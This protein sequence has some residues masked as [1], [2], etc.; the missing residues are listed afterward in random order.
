MTLLE[1][2][3][4]NSTDLL[5]DLIDLPENT[6]ITLIGDL[7][8]DSRET[9]PGDLFIAHAGPLGKR[10]EFIEHAITQGAVMILR[11]AALNTPPLEIIHQDNRIIPLLAVADLQTK[12]SL[13]ASKF[14]HHPDHHLTMIGITGTNGKTSINYF[15]AQGLQKAGI[16]CGMIG[17]LGNGFPGQLNANPNNMTTPDSTSLHK[18]LAKLKAQGAQAVAMEVSSH[19]LTQHRVANI[20]FT[21]AV[22]TNLTRDHLDYHDT[23]ENYGK[24]KETLFF[25]PGLKYAVINLDDSF[26]KALVAKIDSKVTCYTYSLENCDHSPNHIFAQDIKLT[27]H[28]IS[29]RLTTP[30]GEGSLK[31]NLFGRFNLSNLLAALTT[32]NIMGI[33]FSNTLQM[34]STLPPV[35]GR[36]QILGG[37]KMP[38]VVIDY[39]HTPDALE[40]ALKALREHC[41]GKLWCVFGC[42]GNRDAGKRKL[43]GQISERYSDQ[44]IITDDNPRFEDPSLIVD[45]IVDGLLCPWAAEIEHDRRA[46]IA[47]AIDCANAND[48]VL[49]AGKGHERYQQQMNEMIAFDDTEIA[50]QQLQLKD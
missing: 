16:S 47:H 48:I 30:W 39:A 21:I 25:T 19:S 49:I 4:W 45:D 50:K 32:L 26:G 13:I 35:P 14:Y 3:Y 42:G 18:L 2:N 1:P 10:H 43:M 34:L 29:A 23:M 46:A 9:K 7:S 6:P 22:F 36:M 33:P 11:Q 31:S 40:K 37:G 5:K 15:I 12:V 27:T 41:H 17:T 8:V 24:A 38:L 28:G 20:P 44:L